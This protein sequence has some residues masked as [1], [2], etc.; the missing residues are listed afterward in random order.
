MNN[1]WKIFLLILLNIIVSASV[2]YGVLYYWENIRKPKTDIQLV[3]LEDNTIRLKEELITETESLNTEESLPENN[4]EVPEETVE[5]TPVIRGA[6]VEISIIRNPGELEN[7]ALRIVNNTDDI[8]SLENWR[9]ED[10]NGHVLTF[11]NIQ[12]LRKGV[13]VEV[14][15]RAGHT[16]PY[17]IFWNCNEAVWQSGETAVLKDMFGQLQAT[18]RVP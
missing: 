1:F 4:P 10:A 9:L 15:S 17:E 13:F 3:T 6:T 7:E 18:Y 14:Y 2:T 12:L 16:T 5:P 8:V 11:P